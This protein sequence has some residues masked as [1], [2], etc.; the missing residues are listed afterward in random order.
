MWF[1]YVHGLSSYKKVK[2]CRF[3]AETVGNAATA[4]TCLNPPKPS[5][6]EHSLASHTF[7]LACKARWIELNLY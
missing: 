5:E 4:N 6:V 7:C 1:M 2:T 3:R